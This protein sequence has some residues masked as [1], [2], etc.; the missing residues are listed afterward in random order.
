MGDDAQQRA[1]YFENKFDTLP[2]VEL[3]MDLYEALSF[4][5]NGVEYDKVTKDVRVTEC[6]TFISPNICKK[7]AINEWNDWLYCVQYEIDLD[8]VSSD[9]RESFENM[10]AAFIKSNGKSNYFHSFDVNV[11]HPS[12]TAYD[13]ELWCGYVWIVNSS[14]IWSVRAI[15][16]AIRCLNVLCLSALYKIPLRF[17]QKKQ[18]KITKYIGFE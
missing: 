13:S 5:E 18:L 3:S 9:Q 15:R 11:S 12:N 14:S 8:F 2:A 6:A 17:V 7:E 1:Q 10:C 4:S 16:V